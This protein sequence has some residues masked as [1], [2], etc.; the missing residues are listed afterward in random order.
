MSNITLYSMSD[1]NRKIDKHLGK[2]V[3]FDCKYK[4]GVSIINPVYVLSYT[5]VLN[6]NYLYDD[7]T[8]RYYYIDNVVMLPSGLAELHCTV[9]VLKT[10]ADE[11]KAT[12]QMIV[13]YSDNEYYRMKNNMIQ[14]K[15]IPLQAKRLDTRVINTD[16]GEINSVQN[17]L[18][19]VLTTMGGTGQQVKPTPTE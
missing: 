7:F 2:G 9:D 3:T 1:D 17:M 19:F 18:T 16:V 13:R 14:D 5:N 12:T 10:Y 8:K 15:K 4:T 6:Y 11:I